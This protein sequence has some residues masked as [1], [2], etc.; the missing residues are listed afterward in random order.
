MADEFKYS[1][2]MSSVN[3]PTMSANAASAIPTAEA[4]LDDA[5]AVVKDSSQAFARL[6]ARSKAG[7]LR[8]CIARITDSADEWVATGARARGAQPA[9]EWLAGV[10]PTVRGFRLLAESLEHIA[11]HGKPALGR[12]ARVRA[13]GRLA[14]DLFPNS[15]IDKLSLVGFSGY[16]L[17]QEGVDAASA[18]ARQ[19]SFYDRVAP[20]GGVSLVLGAGNVSS[21]PPL[22][23]ASKMFVEGFT[24]IL[25]INPVN[26]WVGSLLERALLP[27][28]SRNYLRIVYGG[29][30]V[31]RYL[32]AS[33][34]ID[35]IHITG[36]GETHDLIV[37]GPPGAERERRMQSNAP[38][39]K[40]PISSE[41][42]NVS[43]VAIV[44][45]RYTDDELWFQAR[46]VL[47][48]VWNNGSFNCNAAK[49]LVTSRSWPQRQRFLGM[50]EDGLRALPTR[51]AYYP[52]AIERYES[53][54]R[55]GRSGV[56]EL[57]AARDG[58]LP[59]A[60]ISDL[61]ANDASEP[62][63][64]I[65]PFCSIL[66]ETALDVADPEEFLERATAFMN[67]RLWGT[68]NAMI[69]IHPRLQR[70]PLVARALDRAIVELRYGTV[71]VNHWP[72]LGY[73]FGT[74][75][76][77]GHETST[78]RDI[79]S[80]LG[81]VHNSCML[82]GIDKSVVRGGLVVRPTPVWFF[83]NAKAG[84]MAPRVARM[85]AAPSLW[86]VPGLVAA[87]LF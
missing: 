6:S 51:L 59:W 63:F 56:L 55:G 70:D 60:L 35:D 47:T 24:C 65:E 22:D 76:W 58:Y 43:P 31:G 48:M 50:I 13:D 27:L 78:L 28:I 29:A 86:K 3:S 8:E 82:E 2:H 25:K 23:A 61:D 30:E 85:E 57:G 9:E 46:N 11:I 75:P 87:A 52:G 84:A 64:R 19:A 71:A 39:L 4:A 1:S 81:W 62:L 12:G 53:L 16:A 83:D 44:P 26:E 14:I 79:Q 20:E 67:E 37:W 18:R 49:M 5:I 15:A 73:A 34:S 32:C 68:L 7:L 40:K 72:A 66:S 42:G 38:L 80:G 33:P 45:H 21:I 17:M 41:L 54:A 10:T 77:G 36:S 69:V 74:T